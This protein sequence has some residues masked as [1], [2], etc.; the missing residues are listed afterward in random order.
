MEKTNKVGKDGGVNVVCCCA[1]LK[2]G[3]LGFGQGKFQNTVM[4]W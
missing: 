1:M 4:S 3:R 2:Q